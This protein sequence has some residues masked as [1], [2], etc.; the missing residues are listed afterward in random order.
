MDG[1][2]ELLSISAFARRVGLAP[3]AL[4][5]YDDCHVLPPAH[6]DGV[7]GYRY[8][9]P[10]QEPRARLVR[11]SG[12][13][14]RA[15]LER[16]RSRVRN[17]TRAADATI[18]AVLRSLSEAGS[19]AW[20]RVG[21]VELA[22][23]ARQV[24]LAVGHD[25]QHPELGCVLVEIDDAEIRL[26]ATDRYRF[27]MRILQPA[28]M[29][30]PSCRF[31][32]DAAALIEIGAWAAR[33]A[34]VTIEI[35]PDGARARNA[36]ASRILPVVDGQFPAYRDMLCALARPQ[37]R[38][39]VD[40]SALLAAVYS[41]GDTPGI[42]LRL[43]EDEVVVSLPDH[44][45]ATALSAVRQED[46]PLTIGFDPAVLAPALEAGVGPDVLLEIST[47]TQ[48]VVVRSADQGSFTT[49]VMPISLGTR[50]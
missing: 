35:G 44:S 26:V 30:G 20:V 33:S 50:I 17:Q 42:A 45:R 43:V 15:V 24:A 6:V 12:E 19:P 14:A 7:T 46:L 34:E 11:S 4:R 9:S 16:H 29:D 48:P 1:T 13:E 37:C 47:V 22:S 49:L 32:M 36:S 31:L 25:E 23:A 5:F 8:Y 39:I 38:V 27:S 3:S 41:C 18:A 10:G 40:R 2:T 28:A 21:G